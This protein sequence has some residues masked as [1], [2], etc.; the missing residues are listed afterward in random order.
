MGSGEAN[1][2]LDLRTMLE[3]EKLCL[4]RCQLLGIKEVVGCGGEGRSLCDNMMFHPG[5][6]GWEGPLDIFHLCQLLH[7]LAKPLRT[8]D[9]HHWNGLHWANDN[10]AGVTGINEKIRL[11]KV[12]VCRTIANNPDAHFML[13]TAMANEGVVERA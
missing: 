3:L 5:S 7:D 2:L 1:R 6:Q 11:T 8:T 10:H 13:S 9:R 4:D 12:A